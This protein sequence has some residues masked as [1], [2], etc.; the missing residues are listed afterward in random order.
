MN[1]GTGAG[2]D[3]VGRDAAPRLGEE[4]DA[5]DR[6]AAGIAGGVDGTDRRSDEE[7]GDD[8][9]LGER[10]QHADLHGTPVAAAAEHE[11]RFDPVTRPREPGMALPM[12]RA[13]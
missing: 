6:R 2:K 8:L 5:L 7:V 3:L 10:T 4:L 9:A 12:A 11:R 1:R 13:P